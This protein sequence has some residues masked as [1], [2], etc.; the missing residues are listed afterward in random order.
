MNEKPFFPSF[1]GPVL[2]TDYNGILAAQAKAYMA[3]M[4]FFAHL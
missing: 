3:S 1:L 2:V 4:V